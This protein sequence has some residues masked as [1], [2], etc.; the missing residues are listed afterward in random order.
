M[1]LRVINLRSEIDELVGLKVL[2]KG[3]ELLLVCEKDV[4]FRRSSDLISQQPR[5]A[6]GLNCSALFL[7][8]I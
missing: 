2:N 1:V 7:V 8:I 5:A 6:N 3:E 4:I